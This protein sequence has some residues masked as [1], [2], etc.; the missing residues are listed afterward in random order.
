MAKARYSAIVEKYIA[1]INSGVLRPGDRIPSGREM[2]DL[3]GVSSIVA[4]RVFRILAE[5][6]L[7][8]LRPGEGY[9]VSSPGTGRKRDKIVCAFRFFKN[10][11]GG[12][13]FGN[14]ILDS[15]MRSAAGFHQSLVLIP[16][17]IKLSG[18]YPSDD[19]VRQMADE[20]FSFRDMAG[21]V[22]DMRISDEQIRRYILPRSEQI[23]V[24][25]AGRQSRLEIMSSAVP[26]WEIGVQL[27]KIA[28]RAAKY[29]LFCSKVVP[30]LPDGL[31]MGKAF[32]QELEKDRAGKVLE[33]VFIEADRS[34]R[35]RCMESVAGQIRK[36]RGEIFIA[37]ASDYCGRSIADEMSARGLEAGKDF[38]LTG[39]GGS[40]VNVA[41]EGKE[42]S[43]IVLDANSIGSNAVKLL[44]NHGTGKV[45]YCSWHLECRET[46]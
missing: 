21:I 37:C 40:G 45:E 27:A 36:Y 4:L 46:F 35:E 24:V 44:M 19:D 10:V 22:L 41:P 25:T 5:Q 16:S 34:A 12:D 43:T 3:F 7:I 17:S 38:L 29:F 31:E 11:G 33:S 42:L 18:R 13:N 28:R 1:D 20:I 32:C 14:K 39:V 30:S 23:P 6:G 15:I 2:K 9:F 26:V 8:V